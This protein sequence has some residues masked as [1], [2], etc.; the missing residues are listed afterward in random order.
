[1]QNTNIY[2]LTSNMFSWSNSRSQRYFRLLFLSFLFSVAYLII[3]L[4]LYIIAL[5]EQM[6]NTRSYIV[7]QNRLEILDR[8]D[9]VLA[10]NITLLSLF[11]NPKKVIDPKLT[12]QKLKTVLKDIDTSKIEKDLSSDKT[13]V[14]IKR[15]LSPEDQERIHSLGLTGLFFEEEQR[16]LYTQ[17]R[18]AGHILGYVDR[19]NKGIAGVEKYFDQKFLSKDE[20]GAVKLSI[21]YR[22]QN[23]VNEELDKVIT[24]FSALGG[25]CIVADVTTGEILAMVSKPDFDPHL[26][27]AASTEQLFNR[28][29]YGV[30]ELGSVLKIITFAIGF[31]TETIQ[32]NDVYNIHDFVMNKFKIKDY[33]RHDGWNTVPQIFM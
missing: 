24:K 11:A 21:D 33:H 32:I 31:D 30:Y 26:P 13:F 4:K 3:V 5:E 1:M 25:S 6:D 9:H 27:G 2:Y 16:R 12:A 7:Q 10:T 22:V 29:S 17:G 8:H 19:D 23:I 15:D 28:A 20:K 14:W 18:A